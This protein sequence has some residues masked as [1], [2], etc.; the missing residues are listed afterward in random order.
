MTE[1]SNTGPISASRAA[2]V[3]HASRSA[4]AA[5]VGQTASVRPER[6]DQVELSEQARRLDAAEQ[7][8]IRT[9]L[10]ERIREQIAKGEY[11]T[12]QRLDATVSALLENL[13]E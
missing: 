9:E 5:D 12:E 13:S 1:I 11:I 2:S 3:A 4:K 7:G 8:T 6:V 10:V